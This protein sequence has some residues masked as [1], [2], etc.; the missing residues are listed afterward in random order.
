MQWI[1]E[2]FRQSGIVLFF[3]LFYCFR[4]F[5]DIAG[6]LHNRVLSKLSRHKQCLLRT[7]DDI[8]GTLHSSVL[9][10][11]SRLKQ[12]LLRTVDDIT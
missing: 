5:D 8:A 12:C 9:S 6:T 2:L 4:Y 10:K 11:L 7:V 1:F 3:L